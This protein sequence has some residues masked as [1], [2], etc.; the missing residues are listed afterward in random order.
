[1]VTNLAVLDFEPESKHMRIQSVHPGVTVDEVQAAT[2][3]ELLLPD[4]DVPDDGRRPRR[5]RCG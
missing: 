5:S 2:G 1:M 3:F 4:G